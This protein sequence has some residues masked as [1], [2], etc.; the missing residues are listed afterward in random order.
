MPDGRGVALP[1]R[2]ARI[3]LGV[4]KSSRSLL[5]RPRLVV[6][7]CVIATA[8]P[9]VNHALFGRTRLAG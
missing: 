6:G 7:Y 8:T 3:S 9:V 2:K 4:W 1:A 5:I